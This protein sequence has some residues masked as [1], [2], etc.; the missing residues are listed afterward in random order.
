MKTHRQLS[1][2]YTGKLFA[3]Y[4][5]H[6]VP[7]LMGCVVWLFS[8]DND[9]SSFSCLCFLV[10]RRLGFTRSPHHIGLYILS[11]VPCCACYRL[12]I[13]LWRQEYITPFW[14]TNHSL[15]SLQHGCKHCK[16]A[17]FIPITLSYIVESTVN[18]SF[19][20]N[21]KVFSA[22]EPVQ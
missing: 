6:F 20:R 15:A 13:S 16:R 17:V 19:T 10:L 14:E 11:Q 5:Y 1:T 9:L 21:Y 7:P 12:H 3:F 8:P 18:F 22:Q 4:A 2:F